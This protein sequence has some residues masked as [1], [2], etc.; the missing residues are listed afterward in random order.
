MWKGFLELDVPDFRCNQRLRLFSCSKQYPHTLKYFV[1]R[2][3]A[4]GYSEKVI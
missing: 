1:Q 3:I 2:Y 4:K